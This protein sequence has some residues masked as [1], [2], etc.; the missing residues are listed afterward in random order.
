M[1]SISVRVA[2]TTSPPASSDAPSS[3]TT[4]TSSMIPLRAAPRRS[5]DLDV[6]PR[7]LVALERQVGLQPG[8]RAGRRSSAPRSASH[9]V[10]CL[11][12]AAVTSRSTVVAPMPRA[13]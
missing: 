3:D 1:S 9:S 7:R 4:C 11:A 5:L 12:C 8:Q 13:G 10:A 6:G 2:L